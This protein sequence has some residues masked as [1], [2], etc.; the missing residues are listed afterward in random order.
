MKY[1]LHDSNSFNDEKITEL[2]MNF[3]YEGL[4]LFYSLL[5]KLASQEKPIKTSVLKSQLKVGKKLEKCWSFME[6]VE[7]IHSNNG[8]TFNKQLMC[9]SEKYKIKKES[10][11]KRVSEWRERQ[12]II[13]TV[14]HY[15]NVCNAT[16]VNESQVN[17]SKSYKDKSEIPILNLN[18]KFLLTIPDVWKPVVN[19]W[20]DFKKERNQSYKGFTSLT[21]MFEKLKNFSNGNP[22]IGLEI[23]ENSIYNNYSGFFKLNEKTEH[24]MILKQNNNPVTN[25]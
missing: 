8:E 22:T 3:G 23:I 9:F 24:A 13:K 6:S 1:Y 20:L 17:E 16:K 11:S 14:T 15:E 2:F 18:E 7:L 12:Q 25:F 19:K 21:T 5:E 10:N 4:G